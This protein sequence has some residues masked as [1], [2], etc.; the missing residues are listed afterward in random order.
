MMGRVGMGGGDQ[1]R[2]T[3]LH[4]AAE[5]GHVAAVRAI[6]AA[7]PAAVHARAAVRVAAAR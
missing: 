6:C 7:A 2:L 5:A 3:A 1:D 4:L